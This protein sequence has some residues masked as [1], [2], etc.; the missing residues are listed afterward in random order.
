[1]VLVLISLIVGLTVII[2]WP[3]FDWLL[4]RFAEPE[5]FYAHGYLIPFISAYLIWQKKAAWVKLKSQPSYWGLGI[6]IFSLIIHVFSY[7]FEINL[8]SG[9]SLLGVIVGLILFNLG[10][11]ALK[12]NVFA[13]FF[14]IFMIPLPKVMTL[15][16]SFYLK[17]FAAQTA[18][19]CVGVIVPLKNV[20]SFIYL[21]NGVLTVGTPCSGLSSLISLAALAMLF[22]HL[23]AFSKFKKAIFF[24]LALPLALI[25]NILR[26]MLLIIVCYVYGVDVAMGWFHDFS[27]MLVFVFAFLGLLILR[28]IFLLW[29]IQEKVKIL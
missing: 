24:I 4:Y 23:T 29:K 8:L 5:S 25:S 15:G 9:F 2:F 1:M 6:L 7:Y 28:N 12:I 17:M 14:L 20:G 10:V 11:E 21:P 13:L 16:L 26:I 18:S 19:F 3:T 27:G 22:S